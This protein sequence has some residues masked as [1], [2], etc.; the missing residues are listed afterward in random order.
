MDLKKVLFRQLDRCMRALEKE[1][2]SQF[3]VCVKLNEKSTMDITIIVFLETKVGIKQ[4]QVTTLL[5]NPKKYP[6][7]TAW[8]DNVIGAMGD[9]I[10]EASHEDDEDAK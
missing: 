4:V 3:A 5:D 9:A 2:G 7:Y 8:L 10:Y 1:F 6:D